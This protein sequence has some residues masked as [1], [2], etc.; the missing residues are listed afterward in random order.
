[1][2]R[3]AATTAKPDSDTR[4]ALLEAAESCLRAHGYAGLSTRRVAEAAGMPLSQIHYH[5]G[6]KEAL[7][8]ALLEQ[9]NRRLLERQQAT[10]GGDV[11]LWQ[12]W[13]KACDHL[14]EDIASGYVRVLQEMIALGWS[15]P[16]IAAAV[17]GFLGGWYAL[18]LGVAKEA[19]ARF[20]GLGPLDPEDVA[21]LVGNGFMG[22]EAMLLLGFEA[23]G[24]PVRRALRRFGALLR[25]L[26]ESV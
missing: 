21:C 10:L 18:L 14:D 5:F 13:E 7:M 17:R 12:R 20:G 15:S 6:S 8:L 24:M 26:E 19:A 2:A 23:E 11:P 1:M 9:L 3:R 16:E 22:A 4:A 25:Q